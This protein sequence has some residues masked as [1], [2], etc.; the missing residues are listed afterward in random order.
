MARTISYRYGG[1]DYKG[2][3]L[4]P[5]SNAYLK[6][7]IMGEHYISMPV[8]TR[9]PLNIG[10]EHIYIYYNDRLYS[11]NQ[12]PASKKQAGDIYKTDLKA[13]SQIYH[14]RKIPFLLFEYDIDLSY[15]Q[16]ATRRNNKPNTSFSI[17]G[18]LREMITAIACNVKGWYGNLSQNDITFARR[19]FVDMDSVP[20]SEYSKTLSFE[21]DNVLSALQKICKE[22]EV[23]YKVDEGEY[24]WATPYVYIRNAIGSNKNVTLKYGEGLTYIER[25]EADDTEKIEAI[26]PFTAKK[27]VPP[28]YGRDRLTLDELPVFTDDNV[29]EGSV[30]YEGFEEKAVIFEEIFPEFNGSV[31]TVEDYQTFTDSGIDFSISDHLLSGVPAKV[32]FNSGDL[33]GREFEILESGTSGDTVKIKTKKDTKGNEIPNENLKMSEGDEYTFIDIE[34]PDSYITDAKNRL[35]NRAK[36]YLEE[37]NSKKIAYKIEVDFLYLRRNNIQLDIGDVISIYDDQLNIDV[38]LRIAELKQKIHK[39][40]KYS[41]VLTNV[42]QVSHY[43]E[44]YNKYKDLDIALEELRKNQKLLKI[45]S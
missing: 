41:I 21:N 36:E 31:D 12:I 20:V 43:V 7:Q 27:N 5:D 30:A 23:E 15:D 45:N 35:E 40:Y 29:F 24:G 37:H 6:K 18:S 28:D 10:S 14:Y 34:M 25:H 33:A 22:F 1:F 3:K 16:L 26:Y 11:I 19:L 2:Q 17:T 4:K 44:L 8:T 42:K 9:K 38:T 13:E 39:P 32:V